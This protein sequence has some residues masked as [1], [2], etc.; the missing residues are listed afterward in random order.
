MKTKDEQV[1]VIIKHIKML[2]N[3]PK[4]KVK[5]IRCDNSGENH[6]IQNYLRV[7]SPRMRCKLKFTAPD[8]PQ[9]IC[10]IE[11]SLLPYMEE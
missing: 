4:N 6:G 10:K 9:Q 7:R 5:N 8:S 1:S 2:Q 3:K 11:G